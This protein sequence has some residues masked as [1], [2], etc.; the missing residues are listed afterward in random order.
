MTYDTARAHY[1]IL[2]PIHV[3]P[4]FLVDGVSYPIIDLSEAGMR[5]AIPGVHLPDPGSFLDGQVKFSR[6]GT[7]PI[8]GEVVRSD[9]TSMALRFKAG[10][11]YAQVMDEQRFLLERN[12]G[13]R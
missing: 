4:T 7:C 2:Y 10:V 12:R 6:G 5:C 9:H 11:P 3:R 13:T 1:R 8:K